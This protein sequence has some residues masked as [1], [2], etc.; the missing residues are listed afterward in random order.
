MTFQEYQLNV[1]GYKCVT[2]FWEDFSIAD[3]FGEAAVKDTY[4]RVFKEW[5][6]DHIY[7]TELVLVLNHKCW[8]HYREGRRD[9]SALYS[10]LYY[11][12]HGYACK[13]LKGEEYEYYFNI[14][15]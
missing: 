2:T 12:A 11:D 5:K 3:L 4:K 7:L 6:H 13:H 1:H 14:T 8:A 10:D 15:D 9:L